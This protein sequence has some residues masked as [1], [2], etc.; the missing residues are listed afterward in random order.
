MRTYLVNTTAFV[1]LANGIVHS[2]PVSFDVQCEPEDARQKI[3]E[4]L[5]GASVSFNFDKDKDVRDVPV[6]LFRTEACYGSGVRDIM[7]IIRHE[8]EEL[9]NVDIPNYILNHYPLPEELQSKLA[10]FITFCEYGA[11]PF[12]EGLFREILD[13]VGK[14]KGVPVRYGLWLATE[15]TVKECYLD[16]GDGAIDAYPTSPVILSDL[17]PDGMLFGYAE[18]PEKI[19]GPEH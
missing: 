10:E 6:I 8:V 19:H 2:I 17:G 18:F 9:G 15:E 16:G 11:C 4:V 14:H 1:H 7:E 5:K 12:D 3:F 13:A